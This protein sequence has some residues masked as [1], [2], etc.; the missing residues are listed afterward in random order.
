MFPLIFPLPYPFSD[1][2]PSLHCPLFYLVDSEKVGRLSSRETIGSTHSFSLSRNGTIKKKCH[3]IISILLQTEKVPQMAQEVLWN[4][5]THHLLI[6]KWQRHI[7]T[8]N[9]IYCCNHL[10]KG[11][12]FDAWNYMHFPLRT[13][14]EQHVG[15]A[16]RVL[17]KN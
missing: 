15:C 5:G 7:S 6:V 12:E 1:Y 17:S 11:T 14:S 9:D 2:L 4:K 16:P 8:A 10:Y 13:D 3:N